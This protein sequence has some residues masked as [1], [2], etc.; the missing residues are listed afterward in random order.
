MKGR[1]ATSPLTPCLAETQYLRT[2]TVHTLVCLTLVLDG[3]FTF[4]LAGKW[5]K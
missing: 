3:H 5:H 4:G 2:Y 1:S